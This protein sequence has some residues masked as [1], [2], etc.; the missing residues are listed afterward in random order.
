MVDQIQG[1][2]ILL[3]FVPYMVKKISICHDCVRQISSATKAIN[4]KVRWKNGIMTKRY[5][6]E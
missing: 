2:W 5:V 1:S 4:E 6:P 3:V